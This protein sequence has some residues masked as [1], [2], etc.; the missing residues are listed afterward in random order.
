MSEHT[1]VDILVVG[2]GL[3]GSALAN[4]L[5]PS[6]QAKQMTLAIVDAKAPDWPEHP[7]FD[8]RSTAISFASHSL[9][10]HLGLWKQIAPHAG[11]IH[12][13]DVSSQG[14]WG[15]TRLNAN[16]YGIDALGWVVP[17][18]V[19]GR[20]LWS[21]LTPQSGLQLHLG[22]AI[23]SID[24]IADG[25]QVLLASGKIL[26]TGL[27]LI[28][29]GFPSFSCRAL[30]IEH[31]TTQYDQFA[32]IANLEFSQSHEHWAYER[33]TRQGPLALLPL[34]HPKHMA[35]VMT[36]SR[37]ALDDFRE[38]Q[39]HT[40]QSAWVKQ[41]MQ[42]RL[43][44]GLGEVLQVGNIAHYPLVKAIVKEPIRHRLAVLGNAA[45]LLHP[46]AGQGFNLALREV[47]LLVDAL[48]QLLTACPDQPFKQHQRLNAALH[49]YQQA[50]AWDQTKTIEISHWLPKVFE[51]SCWG[52]TQARSGM[53]SVLNLSPTSK[54]LFAKQMMGM[55]EARTW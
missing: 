30:G 14:Q 17:N 1:W 33:F 53:L 26:N 25:Y 52:V 21:G 43:R 13:I 15:K 31:Q 20:A 12:H 49:Q 51:S 48:E 46:V 11:P 34:A 39:D 29:D 44:T 22:D 38:I 18:P 7:S 54:N 40:E 10:D 42:Q 50:T 45:H 19:L 2:G 28:A 5:L 3:V 6:L 41:L 23:T 24:P 37:E 4:R 36:L 8:E 32:L 35:L 16:E 9:L 47:S 27:L 55:A